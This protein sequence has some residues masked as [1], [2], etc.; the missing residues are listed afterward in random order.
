MYSESVLSSSCVYNKIE[1]SNINKQ[2]VLADLEMM[3]TV[4]SRATRPPPP[5]SLENRFCENVA[6]LQC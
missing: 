6:A 4:L 2:E 5:V 1:T 3:L